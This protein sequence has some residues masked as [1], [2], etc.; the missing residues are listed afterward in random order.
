MQSQEELIHWHYIMLQ[1]YGAVSTF[2][3]FLSTAEQEMCTGLP[4]TPPSSQFTGKTLFKDSTNFR[5]DR[6]LL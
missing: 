6:C 2:G 4:Q 3:N 1:P 5:L